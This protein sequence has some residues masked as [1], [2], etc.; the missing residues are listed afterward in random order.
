MML[1]DGCFIIGLFRKW[2]ELSPRD[3]HD[4][5]FQLDWMLRKIARDLLLFENQLPFFVLTKL[6]LMIESSQTPLPN[7]SKHLGEHPIKIEQNNKITELKEPGIKLKKAKKFTD[8]KN[9]MKPI[10]NATKLKEGGVKFQK[11]KQHTKFSINFRNGVLEILPLTTEEETETFLRNLIAYEQYSPDVDNDYHYVTHYACFMDD[12]INSPKDV[13]LLRQNEIIKKLLGD[14]GVASSMFNKL[15]RHV[16]T[17]AYP[18]N[19]LYAQNYIDKN[20]DCAED[21]NEWKATLRHNYFN[22][23]WAYL[24]VLVAILLL[25]LTI[26][27]AVFSIIN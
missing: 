23:P 6:F 2:D 13:E 1:L 16:T 26:I 14:D 5:I 21:W 8:S 9:M 20:K 19:T 17:L 25:G 12:L 24:S 3:D 18:H 7:Q 27:Q 11:G 10:H 22:S 4:P 15:C